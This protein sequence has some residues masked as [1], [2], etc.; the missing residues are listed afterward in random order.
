[1]ARLERGALQPA[2]L[3]LSLAEARAILAGLERTMTERQA[4]EFIDQKRPYPLLWPA[5]RVQRSSVHCQ[6]YA[7]R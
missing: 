4:A 6:S 7:V 2:T 1:V 3:G 5:T